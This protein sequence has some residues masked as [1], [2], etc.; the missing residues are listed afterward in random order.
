MDTSNGLSL[1]S[2]QDYQSRDQCRAKRTLRRKIYI[3][4]SILQTEPQ[5]SNKLFIRAD[6]DIFQV[7]NSTY[8]ST[9]YILILQQSIFVADPNY[10]QITYD[11][12]FTSLELGLLRNQGLQR[13]IRESQGALERVE[14]DK[15]PGPNSFQR[16]LNLEKQLIRQDLAGTADLIARAKEAYLIVARTL[17]DETPPVEKLRRLILTITVLE[18][19]FLLLGPEDYVNELFN[20]IDQLVATE[21]A[22]R[23]LPVDI[24]RTSKLGGFKQVACDSNYTSKSGGKPQRT[25]HYYV[26]EEASCVPKFSPLIRRI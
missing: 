5:F 21:A 17:Y 23:L 18:G 24:I 3:I 10:G 7:Y 15:F 1:A 22:V 2:Q 25:Q 11:V 12:Y 19:A 8:N 6:K 4:N 20:S 13:N 14:F 26:L 9:I 16:G